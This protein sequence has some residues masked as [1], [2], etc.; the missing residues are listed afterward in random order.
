MDTWRAAYRYA[1]RIFGPSGA[2]LQ[3]KDQ[4]MDWLYKARAIIGAAILVVVG[5]RYHQGTSKIFSVFNPVLGGVTR[6][7]IIGLF[8]VVPATLLV[9]WYT[10]P[11]KREQEFHQMRRYPGKVVL[12]CL[13]AYGTLR[14]LELTL[15]TNNVAIDFFVT[16]V[17]G[18]LV[19]GFLPFWFRAIYLITVG[20]ARAGD[21]HPLLP[22]VIGAILAWET[23]IQSLVTKQVG[24]GAPSV[25]S[26]AVLLG[27][28]ISI[29]LLGYVE[30]TRLRGRYPREFP[31][32]DGPLA[33]PVPPPLAAAPSS[34]RPWPYLWLA[35]L[36]SAVVPG[37]AVAAIAWHEVENPAAVD[38]SLS[39]I[40]YG[41]CIQNKPAPY[42]TISRLPVIPCSDMHWGQFLGLVSIGDPASTP[43]PCDAVSKQESYNACLKAFDDGVGS[44]SSGY[45]VWYSYPGEDAWDN[46]QWAN[47][48][49]VAEAADGTSFK[50]SLTQ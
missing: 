4:A 2:Y 5:V 35:G 10:K 25:I 8:L 14:I 27:G 33:A 41:Q 48:A 17:G 9:V 29:T 42:V 18:I 40:Q 16:I 21:G 7:M 39:S 23:A 30:I 28:P 46:D 50:G 45:T 49:C 20:I 43:Y 37:I 3:D 13:L 38:T 47:A 31:F 22:P 36:V 34:P 15:Q 11:G 6:P 19:L 44:N 32:R 26:L 12:I 24:T 1:D